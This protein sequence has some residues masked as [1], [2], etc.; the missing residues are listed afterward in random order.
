MFF[1]TLS[2]AF[3]FVPALLAGSR[4]HPRT[5]AVA[6]T[7][8]LLGWTLI[9]WIACLVWALSE[10]APAAQ[11][12]YLPPSAFFATTTYP[13]GWSA[14]AAEQ[15]DPCCRACGRPVLPAATFCSMCGANLAL[16]A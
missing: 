8:L 14:A 15:P 16:R 12:T 11:P 5:T 1:L 7:N 10:P 3:Y 6:L 9:G 2:L 13:A 4:H